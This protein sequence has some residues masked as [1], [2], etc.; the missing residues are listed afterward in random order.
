MLKI[1]DWVNPHYLNSSL[2]KYYKNKVNL[3]DNVKILVL[4]N[5]ILKDKMKKI[6]KDISDS[7]WQK[8]NN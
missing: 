5:F 3:M 2:L 6:N 8:K 4:D 7:K 1:W